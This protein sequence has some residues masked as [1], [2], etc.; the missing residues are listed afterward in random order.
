MKSIGMFI[1]S[2]PCATNVFAYSSTSVKVGPLRDREWEFMPGRRRVRFSVLSPR[3]WR[4]SLLG[5]IL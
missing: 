4:L 3:G 5:H 2:E 1:G